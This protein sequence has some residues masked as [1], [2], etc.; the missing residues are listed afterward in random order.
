MALLALILAIAGLLTSFLLF[1]IIPSVLGLITS[2]I[3]MGRKSSV[4]ATVALFLSILGI[5]LPIFFFLNTYGFANPVGVLNGTAKPLEQ[6]MFLAAPVPEEPEAAGVAGEDLPP[7]GSVPVPADGMGEIIDASQFQTELPKELRE[8]TT[9]SYDDA[10][11]HCYD[12]MFTNTSAEPISASFTYK[13]LNKNGEV[14]ATVIDTISGI[15]AGEKFVTE[16]VFNKNVGEIENVIYE[17][18]TRPCGSTV[19]A[20]DQVEVTTKK[21]GNGERVEVKNNATEDVR[22]NVHVLFYNGNEVVQ[23]S[24]VVPSNTRMFTISPRSTGTADAICRAGSY[25]KTEVYY[26]ALRV[27]N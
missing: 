17:V 26:G 16:A 21:I 1:G 8:E 22:V 4:S 12:Y 25:T 10:Y 24:W 9:F 14:I 23:N 20:T 13:A 7:S 6:P 3:A 27:A 5:L 2:L 19:F 11:A 18:E 15:P